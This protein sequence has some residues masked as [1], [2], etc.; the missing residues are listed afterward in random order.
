MIAT[1]A[2]DCSPGQHGNGAQGSGAVPAGSR[3]GRGRPK[4]AAKKP[5][6]R[7]PYKSFP[8]TPH[9]GGQFCKKIN[10]R[11]V[12]FGGDPEEALRRY[13][14]HA[15]DLHAGRIA[16]VE[17]TRELTIGDLA[18][19]YLAEAETRRE[20]GEIE[21]GTFHDYVADCRRLV[22]YFGKTRSVGTITREDF[23]GLR[24]FLAKDVA[25]PTLK[26]RVVTTRQILKFGVD[27]NLVT[28]P[29]QLD[30]LRIPNQKIMRT[31]R[32]VA[33]R[34]NFH[35]S[36]V[37]QAIDA[38]KSLQ[39][40]A[41]ILLAI[42][43]GY[44]NTD[45]AT[46]RRSD[47]DLDGGWLKT[48]RSKTGVDRRC[49]LWPET[50][51][52][53]RRYLREGEPLPDEQRS[54]ATRGLL[55]VTRNDFPLVRHVTKPDG[56][57]GEKLIEHDVITTA[58]RRVLTKIGVRIKGLGFYGLRHTFSTIGS[59]TGLIVA[60]EHIMGHAPSGGDMSAVYRHG[61]SGRLLRQVANHVRDRV[62]FGSAE[63]ATD[64]E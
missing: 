50:I 58:F 49:P 32:A 45:I 24:A 13:H 7:K 54:K 63:P 59:E 39:L 9:A 26:R 5:K 30:K 2:S 52:A 19:R 36:E 1:R 38:T 31:H 4:G 27:E 47:L 62:L 41:V 12:Y 25:P 34:K 61:V 40:R 55:F 35:A 29:L 21:P 18:N 15:D 16:R 51:E 42:N 60:V 46:L 37:K 43:C 33:G 10:G 17:S 44:G 64:E 23:G 8:L 22:T 14:E 6:L 56:R 11:T 28:K 3:S 53:I 48:Y 20:A 57:G